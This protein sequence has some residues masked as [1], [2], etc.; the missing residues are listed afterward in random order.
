MTV[1]LD[2]PVTKKMVVTNE[3]HGTDST[4]QN[5]VHAR[6]EGPSFDKIFTLYTLIY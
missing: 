3:T 5:T 6:R 1:Q 4:S 2:M